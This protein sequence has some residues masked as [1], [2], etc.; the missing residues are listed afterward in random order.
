[1]S[2]GVEGLAASLLPYQVPGGM[3]D[4]EQENGRMEHRI[5]VGISVCRRMNVEALICY[6][7]E[8]RFGSMGH[9][10]MHG[11]RMLYIGEWSMAKGEL[12]HG[13]ILE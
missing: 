8:S 2:H 3:G 1:M 4:W 9:G 5:G 7:L 12:K 13:F 6:E 10:W 11:N